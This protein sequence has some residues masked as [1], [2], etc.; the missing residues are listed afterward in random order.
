MFSYMEYRLITSI[1]LSSNIYELWKNTGAASYSSI[2]N[3]ARRLERMN[4]IDI[5]ESEVNG[6]S[7]S[8]ISPG[9]AYPAF[10]A[11]CNDFFNR[12]YSRATSILKA[13]IAE[14]AGARKLTYEV[15][16]GQ[17][18]P[19]RAY[20]DVQI[21]VPERE[22]ARWKAA[23]KGIEAGVN[24]FGLTIEPGK[25]KFLARKLQ[26]IPLPFRDLDAELREKLADRTIRDIHYGQGYA[27]LEAYFFYLQAGVVNG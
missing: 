5:V 26:V 23:L 4:V 11:I 1:P 8:K 25:T 18:D 6:R 16:G 27:D 12:Y 13:Q 22:Q 15:I 17:L 14:A 10:S 20:A 24:Y 19:S 2:Y 3:L 7:V 21:A 9:G